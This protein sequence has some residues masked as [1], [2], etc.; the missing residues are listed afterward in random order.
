[1]QTGVYVI[2]FIDFFLLCLIAF[3]KQL[4]QVRRCLLWLGV[5]RIV[6]GYVAGEAGWIVSEVG[7]QPWTIQGLLPVNVAISGVNVSSVRTTFILFAVIFT[8][9]LVA[10][11]GILLRE[12]IKGPEDIDKP[13]KLM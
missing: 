11:V 6:L 9:L 2:Y 1:M 5:F 8:V 10:E 12:I 13:L 4:L 7:R 3:C